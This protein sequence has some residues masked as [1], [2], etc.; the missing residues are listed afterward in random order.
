MDQKCVKAYW[1]VPKDLFAYV[2]DPSANT[3]TMGKEGK[4]QHQAAQL[5]SAK[6]FGDVMMA[7]DALRENPA[8][9]EAFEET[10]RSYYKVREAFEKRLVQE[11]CAHRIKNV[12]LCLNAFFI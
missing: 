3:Y 5:Y 11:Q 7:Y 8:A 12:Q 6:L 2:Y 1:K 4:E 9:E 10:L